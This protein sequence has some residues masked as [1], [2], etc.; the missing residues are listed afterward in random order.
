MFAHW[1]R[2]R[3][4]GEELVTTFMGNFI[5]DRVRW[6]EQHARLTLLLLIVLTIVA[7]VYSSLYARIDSDLSKL[8]KPSADTAW[9]QDNEEYKRIFP[10]AQQTAVIVVS[11]ESYGEVELAAQAL[12]INLRKSGKFQFVRTPGL[13]PFIKD[14]LLYYL[15]ISDLENWVKAVQ[16]NY[17]TLLRLSEDQSLANIVLILADQLNAYPGMVLPPVLDSLLRSIV[18][19]DVML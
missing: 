10:D 17:G 6:V 8:I 11:G 5:A 14:H 4:L 19:A 2:G 3:R 15:E 16:F 7:G 9:Y 18:Q 12:A 1:P 13:E